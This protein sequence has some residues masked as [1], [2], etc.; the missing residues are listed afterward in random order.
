[1][2]RDVLISVL[3]RPDALLRLDLP[4]WELLIRQAWSTQL[5]A[6]LAALC[7]ERGWLDDVPLRPRRHLEAALRLGERQERWVRWE[8]D[9]IRRAV[10]PLGIPV[11]LLKGAAYVAAQ[12]PPAKGRIF[13]DID[14]LVERA[15]L[16]EV[17]GA[18]FAH[19]WMQKPLDAYDRRYYR[20]W[21][22][23]VPPRLHV[24]RGT[25]IDLHHTITPPT[26]RF[27]VDGAKIL[28]TAQAVDIP[29][30]FLVLAPVDI[31]LH[32]VAHLFQEEFINGLR[33][34]ADIDDLLRHFG[35]S[36][37]FWAKLADRTRE[38]GLGRLLY[39]ATEQARRILGT[40]M[41]DDFVAEIARY[42]SGWP[43]RAVMAALL[44]AGLAP[45][46][47]SCAPPFSGLALRF[48]YVRAHYLRMPLHLLIPHLA[49]KG[50]RGPAEA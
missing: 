30:R 11:V 15:R 45:R 44:P 1:M 19:G 50:W 4:Q 42:R 7:H 40:P 38:L 18:L 5:I 25:V 6:R 13:N 35:A 49:R 27:A 36:P 14:I 34:L 28:A 24:R 23:E 17:E 47:P 21:M 48:L 22:H 32:S 46:H 26:S 39:Y 12:L 43:I 41:P 9:C 8:I 3:A 29:G 10:A 16:P 20:Q 37:E 2:T 31:V 33:D